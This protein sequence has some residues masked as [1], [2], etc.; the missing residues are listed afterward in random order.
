MKINK[1]MTILNYILLALYIFMG[2][3]VVYSINDLTNQVKLAHENPTN[4]IVKIK[5]KDLP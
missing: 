5:Q 3:L 1:I 4:I 2:I